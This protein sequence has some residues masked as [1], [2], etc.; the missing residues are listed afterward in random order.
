MG[1]WLSKPRVKQEKAM[2]FSVY[3]HSPENGE[4]IRNVMASSGIGPVKH[5][6]DF[7]S[8]VNETGADVIMV[9]Y[10]DNNPH[11]DNWLA[12]AAGKPHFPKIFLFMQEISPQALWKL[13]K[14]GVREIFSRALSPEDF[15]NALTRA[16]LRDIGSQCQTLVGRVCSGCP[17]Q[18]PACETGCGI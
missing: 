5:I 11:L 8:L 4:Y 7:S 12:Q 16:G 6:Q 14:L 2:K 13:I 10:Q 17:S 1:S 9:E 3:Y 15:H 18:S